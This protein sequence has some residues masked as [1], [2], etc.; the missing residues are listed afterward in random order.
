M[1]GIADAVK[2]IM[3]GITTF[4]GAFNFLASATSKVCQVADETAS[5]YLAEERVK[6]QAALNKL[7]QETGVKLVA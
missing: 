7:Q 4:A 1:W 6:N 3:S 2:A 5:N